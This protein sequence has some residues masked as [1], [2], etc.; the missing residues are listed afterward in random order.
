VADARECRR[1][2]CV[3]EEEEAVKANENINVRR[4]DSDLLG[5]G[6]RFR[7]SL[8]SA[9]A[10]CQIWAYAGGSPTLISRGKFGHRLDL[11]I[12]PA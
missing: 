4:G 12:G 10:S 6:E 1:N 2:R 9:A 7:C 11:A 3:L 5:C 8:A